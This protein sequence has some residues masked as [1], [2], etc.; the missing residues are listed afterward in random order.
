MKTFF[1][2]LL[3]D[4]KKIHDEGGICIEKNGHQYRFLPL[5]TQCSLDLPAKSKLQGIV[6]HNG[7]YA[8]G[9]CLHSGV[10]IKSVRSN[11]SVVRY[12]QKDDVSSRTHELFYEVYG[13]P[14]STQT[15]G[16]KHSSCMTAA[17]GI[18]L[19]NLFSIDYLHC[20]LLGVTRKQLDLFLDTKNHTEK[21]YI[22]KKKQDA[23]NKR[24]T[25]IKPPIEIGRKPRSIF[26]RSN[27]KGNE[28]RSILLYY[29]RFCLEG[30][31]PARY[32]DHIQLLSS[33]I[34][35]LLQEKISQEDLLLAESNLSQYADQFEKLYGRHNITMNVHLLRHISNA[36]RHLGPVWTQSTF[37]FEAN[38]GVIVASRS[39]KRDFL[40]QL[41]WKYSAK[42]TLEPT[43]KSTVAD[44]VI[45]IGAKAFIQ[46]NPNEMD[47]INEYGLDLPNNFTLF[48]SICMRGTKYTSKNYK[49]ISTIDY[50]ARLLNGTIG[51]IKFYF[52][53]T[54]NV[55]AFIECYKTIESIDHLVEIQSAGTYVV[56]KINEIAN[57]LI[58]MA[59]GKREIITSIPNK[60]EKT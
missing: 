9:Y 57:K 48:S 19:V 3:K 13:N 52:V 30:L 25:S 58:Y 27:F 39:A 38:N 49:T 21:F 1:Y 59:I 7:Y 14:T 56:V 20:V 46:I 6:N 37:G 34:Y 2:P 16:I 44:Q 42:L 31:L 41:A 17:I 4:L 43:E 26:E 51:A 33:A 29:I 28:L 50:F 23:L 60:F 24:L 35:I 54:N 10:P 53:H 18:D 45:S 8:C 47:T 55:Y 5:I 40:Q 22:P 11:K 15:Y 32:I 12:I 36:V